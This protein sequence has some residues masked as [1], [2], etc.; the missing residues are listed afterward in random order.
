MPGPSVRR[1]E[2]GFPIVDASSGAAA[3]LAAMRA[4]HI[5][6]AAVRVG[7]R[8]ALV[9]ARDILDS[10]P[11]EK[12]LAEIAADVPDKPSAKRYFA[13]TTEATASSLLMIKPSEIKLKQYEVPAAYK[14]CSENH[15]HI[16][17]ADFPGE[18]CPTND[19][20]KLILVF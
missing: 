3:A 11:A 20:G 19:G 17:D 1:S 7:D 2:I 6:G 14:E 12:T 18:T 15:D 5:G 13:V 9:R 10:S 16:F 8:F 4:Y